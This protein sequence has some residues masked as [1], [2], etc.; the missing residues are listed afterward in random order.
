MRQILLGECLATTAVVVVAIL[1]SGSVGRRGREEKARFRA[2]APLASKNGGATPPA[3]SLA[4]AAEVKEFDFAA[5]H[6]LVVDPQ[7]VLVAAGFG[8]GAWRA[9]L[10]AHAGGSLENIGGKRATVPVELD[11]QITSVADPGDLIAGIEDDY[12]REYTNEN[13]AFGHVESLQ[14]TVKS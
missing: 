2:P 11:A 10:Q 12:F 7:A 3:F 6:E 1:V 5:A 13:G 4:I 14:S 8:A 9:G